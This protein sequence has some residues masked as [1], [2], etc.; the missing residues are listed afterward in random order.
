[1]KK[2][3]KNKIIKEEEKEETKIKPGFF[4]DGFYIVVTAEMKKKIKKTKQS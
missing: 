4:T 2:R 1:M 3:R